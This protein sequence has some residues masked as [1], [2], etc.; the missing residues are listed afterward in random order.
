MCV[1]HWYEVT[2]ERR[3]DVGVSTD[4]EDVMIF[5][6]GLSASP[7]LLTDLFGVDDVHSLD[8]E[9]VCLSVSSLPSL[10]IA[11]SLT[12]AS[13]VVSDLSTGAPYTPLHASPQRARTPNRRARRTSIEAPICET[14]FRRAGDRV[15]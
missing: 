8:T 7:A 9:M 1:I 13:S 10:A 14:E 11:S 6:I 12:S 3:P 2:A 15:Q 5:W 4:N